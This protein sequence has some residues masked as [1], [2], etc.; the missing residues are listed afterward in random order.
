MSEIDRFRPD[1]R[2]GVDTLSRRTQGPDAAASRVAGS[3]EGDRRRAF[4]RLPRRSG[5]F[6]VKSKL[7]PGAKMNTVQVP[8]DEETGDQDH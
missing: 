4:R 1:D 2:R 7:E 8:R 6:N 5:Y 3:R